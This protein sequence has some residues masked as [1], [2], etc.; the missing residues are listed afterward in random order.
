MFILELAQIL[1]AI[2]RNKTF[3]AAANE[4]YKVRSALTYTIKNM[5]IILAF[6]YL[7]AANIALYLHLED[8]S[9]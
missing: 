4:L 2:D 7:I 8:G 9:Y 5:K 1:D 6:K 3:E